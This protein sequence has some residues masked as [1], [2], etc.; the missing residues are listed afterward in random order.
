MSSASETRLEVRAQIIHFVGLVLASL[1]TWMQHESIATDLFLSPLDEHTATDNKSKLEKRRQGR[2]EKIQGDFY[3]MTGFASEALTKF[4]SAIERARTNGDSLWLA[5]AMEGAVAGQVYVHVSA[6]NQA[7]EPSLVDRIIE[8]YDEIFRMYRKKRVAELE[9]GAALRLAEYL[10]R[11]TSRRKEAIESAN[12][13][14]NV[15]RIAIY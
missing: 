5:G 9:A 12:L 2:L 11:W 15:G 3:L 7:D 14:A 10:G 4:Y 13:A 6:G 1:E 8:Q